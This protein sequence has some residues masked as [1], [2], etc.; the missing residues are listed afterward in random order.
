M[1]PLLFEVNMA[2]NE[3][4]VGANLNQNFARELASLT[5]TNNVVPNTGVGTDLFRNYANGL[6]AQK[7]ANITGKAAQK[8]IDIAPDVLNTMAPMERAAA[9]AAAADAGDQKTLNALDQK[10][11]D[12][13]ALRRQ[14]TVQRSG[15]DYTNDTAASLLRGIGNLGSGV[16]QLAL[17]L[18]PPAAFGNGMRALGRVADKLGANNVGQA[19]SDGG[20]WLREP[21]NNARATIAGWNQSLQDTA[22]EQMSLPSRVALAQSQVAQQLD[23]AD[24]AAQVDPNGNQIW[25]TAK[26]LGRDA[27]SGIGNLVDNPL[28]ASD[29]IIQQLPQLAT[30]GLSRAAAVSEVGESVASGIITKAANAAETAVIKRGGTLAEAQ[31]ARLSA[32]SKMA[33]TAGKR[34]AERIGDVAARNQVISIGVQEAGGAADGATQQILQMSHDQLMQNSKQYRGYIANGMSQDDAK[35]AVAADAGN[36]SAAIQLPLAMATGRIAARFE[37]EPMSTGAGSVGRRAMNASQNI[38]KEVMEEIPQGITGQMAQNIGVKQTANE[39][40]D[41]LEGV[42]NAAAQSLVGAAGMAGTVQA[43]GVIIPTVTDAA[44][45]AKNAVGNVERAANA[46]RANNANNRAAD[47]DVVQQNADFQSAV[48]TYD[49]T[50]GERYAEASTATPQTKGESAGNVDTPV[51]DNLSAVDSAADVVAAPVENSDSFSNVFS[52]QGQQAIKDI[53]NRTESAAQKLGNVMQVLENAEN[54]N[55]EVRRALEIYANDKL[56]AMLNHRDAIQ[57]ALDSGAANG[58]PDIEA[59]LNDQASAIDTIVN[60]PIAQRL[61]DVYSEDNLSQEDFDAAIN[62]LPSE[63]NQDNVNDPKVQAAF[64]AIKE[65]SVNAPFTVTGDQYRQ[66]LNHDTSLTPIQRQVLE[67]KA[68]LA[69]F[70]ASHETVSNNI[71]NDSRE[72]FQSVRDHAANIFKAM[73]QKNPAQVQESLGALRTF[74]EKQIGRFN[75]H[76]SRMADVI[77][78]NLY[79]DNRYTNVPGYYRLDSKGNKATKALQFVNPSPAGKANLRAIE[80]DTNH[81][82]DVYNALAATVPGAD[83]TQLSRVANTWTQ[84]RPNSATPEEVA[85]FKQRSGVTDV[86]PAQTNDSDANTQVSETQGATEQSGVPANESRTVSS[87]S[88]PVDTTESGER[89]ATVQPDVASTEYTQPALNEADIAELSDAQI[90]DLM[91]EAQNYIRDNGFDRTAQDNFSALSDAQEARR[92]PVAEEAAPTVEETPEPAV[93][94]S[95]HTGKGLLESIPLHNDAYESATTAAEKSARTN[96]LA[97]SFEPSNSNT[98]FAPDVLSTPAEDIAKVTGYPVTEEMQKGIA[99]L[100]NGVKLVG[101]QL[102]QSLARANTKYKIVDNMNG[103]APL[104]ARSGLRS[105]FATQVVDGNLQY[106][107]AV[108]EAMGLSGVHWVISSQPA[109]M[110][111]DQLAKMMGMS[112]GDLVSNPALLSQLMNGGSPVTSVANQMAGMMERMLGIKEKA[113]TSRTYGRTIT[114]ALARETL[115]AM[116]NAGLVTITSVPVPGSKAVVNMVKPVIDDDLRTVKAQ[117]GNGIDIIQDYVLPQ[118]EK[119]F[120]LGKAENSVAKKVNGDTWQN[121]PSDV[122]SFI[123]EQQKVPWSLNQDFYNMQQMLGQQTGYG[124][125]VAAGYYDGNLDNLNVAHRAVIE[126]KNLGLVNGAA[127]ADRM[128]ERLTNSE[129]GLETPIFWKFVMDTNGRTR[130][131]SA[132]NPQ[133]NKVMREIFTATMRDVN[134]NNAQQMR[135]W[136]LHLAQGFKI[137]VDKMPNDEA[138]QKVQSMLE[139]DVTLG[140]AINAMKEGLTNGWDKVT[141]EQAE[142]I[143]AAVRGKNNKYLHAILSAATGTLALENGDTSFKHALTFEVDGVTDGPGNAFVH[144]GMTDINPVTLD[145]LKKIGWNINNPDLPANIVHG[146]TADMYL[147]SAANIFDLLPSTSPVMSLLNYAGQTVDDNENVATGLKRSFAKLVVTPATYGSGMRSMSATIGTELVNALYTHLSNVLAGKDTLNVPMLNAMD[148]MAGGNTFGSLANAS[149]ETLRNFQVP[150]ATLEAFQSALFGE[151]G[152]A[153]YHGINKTVGGALVNNKEMAALTNLQGLIFNDAWKTEYNRLRDELVAKGELAPNEMLSARD[154]QKVTK[155]TE[156][157]A[158]IYQNGI[159]GNDRA[160]G[161]NMGTMQQ[162]GVADYLP[163]T[164]GNKATVTTLSGKLKSTANGTELTAPGVRTVA[165]ATI[166]GGDATMMV[167]GGKALSNAGIVANNVFDGLDTAVGDMEQASD[168]INQAV[169]EGWQQDVYR[170]IVSGVSKALEGADYSKLSDDALRSVYASIMGEDTYKMKPA[171]RRATAN[172]NALSAAVKNMVARHMRKANDNH[173]VRQALLETYSTY[174]HMGGVDKPY[175]AGE[176][177]YEGTPEEV[178]MQ[179]TARVNELKEADKAGIKV[180]NEADLVNRMAENGTNDNGIISLSKAQLLNA[181]ATFDFGG[182]K[183]TRELFKRLAQVL[184]D[185]LQ[186]FHGEPTAIDQMQRKLFPDVQF[187]TSA[188]ASTYGDVIFLRSANSE[189]LLHEAIHAGIQNA[190]NR[191]YADPASMTTEQQSALNNLETLMNQFL[192]LDKQNTD[193]ATAMDMNYAINAIR[194]QNNPAAALNEFI[195]WGL[196]N[197]NLQNFF[198]SRTAERGAQVET[199]FSK[200]IGKLKAAVLKLLG[201]PAS[202]GQSILEAMAGNFDNLVTQI[203]ENPS[204][205]APLTN[206]DMQQL[207]NVLNHTGNQTH[208]DYI[209]ALVTRLNAAT[210]RGIKQ[211]GELLAQSA[212]DRALIQGDAPKITR[213]AR[214]FQSAG[215]SMSP[216]EQHAFLMIQSAMASGLQLNPTAMNAMQRLYDSV[217]PTLTNADLSQTQLDALNGKGTVFTDANGRTTQ[218]ANF[219]ALAMTNEGFRDAL[220]RRD[221]PRREQSNGDL[222]D[223]LAQGTKDL[224]DFFADFGNGTRKMKNA[225]DAFDVLADKIADIQVQTK[226]N[227]ADEATNLLGKGDNF[228]SKQFGKLAESAGDLRDERVLAGKNATKVDQAVNLIL[229]AVETLDKKSS[230]A[231]TLQSAIND[232]NL[233]TPVKELFSEMLGTSKSSMAVNR[234]LQ[235]AK[236]QVSAV[237]QKIRETVPKNVASKFSRDM[238]PAEWATM[239][240]VLGRTDIQSLLTDFKLD[241]VVGWLKDSKSLDAQVSTQESEVSA[242]QHGSDYLVRAKELAHYMMTGDNIS[243]HLLRNA[244]A[245]A[246]LSGT[247][248]TVKNAAM[249]VPAIDKLVSLYALQMVDPSERT[250]MQSIVESERAGVEFVTN[251]M[252]TLNRIEESKMG[253][254]NALNGYKGAL[255]VMDTSHKQ[256][257][258]ANAV[259]GAKLVKDFGFTKVDGY[260]TDADLGNNTLAYYYTSENLTAGYTQGAL[261][262]VEPLLHGVDPITGQTTSLRGS[263]G[264][265]GTP[266]QAMARRKL[267]RAVN[268]KLGTTGGKLMPVFNENGE[269]SGYEAPIANDVRKARMDTNTNLHELLGVMQG[270]QAEETL[271]QTFNQVFADNLAKTWNADKGTMR[272]SEYIDLAKSAQTN[273]VHQQTWAAVPRSAQEML[274]TAFGNDPVMIREDMLNNAFG[275]RNFSVS[276]L[277][278]NQSELPAPVQG[279]IVNVATALLGANAPRY[280]RTAGRLTQDAVSIA[281]DMI[282][283]RSV[284][285]F[286]M[287]LLGNFVQLGQ[288]GVG[289]KD[290]FKG[291]AA[292]MQEVDAYLRNVTKINELH[293]DNLGSTDQNQIKKNKLAM[294]RLV[295]ANKRMS[296]APLIDSGELP[297]VAEGLSIEDDNA[298]RGNALNWMENLMDKLPKGVSDAAR[299]AMIAKGTPLHNGLN[300]MMTYGDFVAKAVLFDKLIRD[301]KSKEDALRYVQEEFINY[302]NNPGRTRTW[303]ESHGFTW[304]LTYKLKIQKIL[305]RRMRDNP[306]S[307]LVYQGAADGLGIDS[308]FEANLAGDNFWYSFSDPTRVLD[309]PSMHPLAQVLR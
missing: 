138:I 221:I 229:G 254:Y 52:A 164:V 160:N 240:N 150:A 13:E 89:S 196:A 219:I 73:A 261:Q 56:N 265:S 299:L 198:G 271:A 20:N 177:S 303:F 78:T 220:A 233:W 283:V 102:A 272:K 278:T 212:M 295:D 96:Q 297:T 176:R 281:K 301:G 37:T 250:A 29:I 95:T 123:T 296:I 85:A 86:Q 156:H 45:R 215:W 248:K 178:A 51:S 82:V 4:N 11:A 9:Y 91:E 127:A 232:S 228:V 280:L 59:R 133:S 41:V 116:S 112:E 214:A 27:A 108:Q 170:N 67:S 147:T 5:P 152:V 260:V 38:G 25:E 42:G 255:P 284:S 276:A 202:R 44:S 182:N 57:S 149:E 242:M 23:E 97:N 24:S 298:I 65:R 77:K 191:F 53:D 264:L 6:A 61:L 180:N 36:L 1:F 144:F 259:E 188:N 245:I 50:N 70:F 113:T 126:S 225:R 274:K 218:L 165:L 247:G 106:I 287:N 279:G 158:P 119:G 208:A 103:P 99:A 55:P 290:I 192:K 111:I 173:Y 267:S 300:R 40:Q 238:Q 209:E 30:G 306:L 46:R 81:I 131:D 211:N 162:N 2:G 226:A 71:R 252:Q 18:T 291:Q 22:E 92:Q 109:N 207:N 190:V 187:S 154:E 234:M 110:S 175:N 121:T 292:K 204:L 19:L 17:E 139:S 145:I 21:T 26:R 101:S 269:V 206:A 167:K 104:S 80:E 63:I 243:D 161:F 31:A 268:P 203:S 275:Y 68:Q 181:L 8:Q 166:S 10:A 230:G 270:R 168:L 288:N 193:Y 201:I 236:N 100:A 273:K 256:L 58:R 205:N 93:S 90:S 285:V 157:L 115:E 251:Y 282:I 186:V 142:D 129:G 223:N 159:T 105:L 74:A 32:A 235:Q 227:L 199:T 286:T 294:Q 33:E 222:M 246:N 124:A 146:E 153:L 3:I 35:N 293:S 224:I 76:D 200:I 137:D 244:T 151:L 48:N 241:D 194:G 289:L 253:N 7:Q 43:P 239:H 143:V 309:A 49:S 305:L 114:N 155:A 169:R 213:A 60:N 128:V 179:L 15:L 14:E 197:Q 189:T 141:K 231:D 134:T 148:E 98:N 132:Y 66:V 117:L 64:T 237:R 75:A 125:L 47:A 183:V 140:A 174:S 34:N 120:S 16:S 88:G 135:E 307:T 277:F 257:V 210:K 79:D 62:G 262:T 130:M 122:Q 304:F 266:A 72:E 28:A 94:D 12:D 87:E 163:D 107:P 83:K 84:V 263:Y 69:D 39:K 258:V 184:P 195:A 308:P 136:Y 302:D 216:K 171:D 217:M 185:N 54:I 172:L 118:E 249:N